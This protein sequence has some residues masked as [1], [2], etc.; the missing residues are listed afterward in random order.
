MRYTTKA[1]LVKTGTFRGR[2]QDTIGLAV[3]HIGFSDKE[4]DFLTGMRQ[5]GGGSTR[6]SSHE[7]I[8]E[9]NYGIHVAPGVTVM[10]NIQYTFN[11]A[12]R[13]PLPTASTILWCSVCN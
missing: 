2:D 8:I 5:V 6:V 11:P 4:V 10:P 3:S 7:E 9:L 13:Q 12:T 1:G